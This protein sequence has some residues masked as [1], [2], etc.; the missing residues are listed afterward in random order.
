MGW[1]EVVARCIKKALVCCQGLG[2]KNIIHFL[3]THFV[4]IDRISLNVYLQKSS[5]INI[6]SKGILYVLSRQIDI[7]QK[8]FRKYRDGGDYCTI[9][10]SALPGKQ[11]NSNFRLDVLY[12][13][14]R[15]AQQSRPYVESEAL[16]L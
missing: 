2:K 5:Q 12:Y 1:S 10:R 14:D 7:R 3:R 4:G 8:Y 15:D 9:L 6:P 11:N 16:W 13:L